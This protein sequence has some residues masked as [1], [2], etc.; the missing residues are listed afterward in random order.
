MSSDIVH[1]YLEPTG[2][3]LHL[4]RW[5]RVQE[6]I[7]ENWGVDIPSDHK[8]MPLFRNRDDKPLGFNSATM[9][10][11]LARDIPVAGLW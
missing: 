11:T 10:T 8:P 2:S 6:N 9:L 1:T 4:E 5:W 7:L 3:L